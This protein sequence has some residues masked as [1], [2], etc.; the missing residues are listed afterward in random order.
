MQKE[1]EK[2]VGVV[3]E[4]LVYLPQNGYSLYEKCRDIEYQENEYKSFRESLKS[5][6]KNLE[7]LDYL[8]EMINDFNYMMFHQ[9]LFG[10]LNE[11]ELAKRD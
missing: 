7:E 6:R 4:D 3:K 8:D 11:F 5:K 2:I 10:E 1:R 9:H